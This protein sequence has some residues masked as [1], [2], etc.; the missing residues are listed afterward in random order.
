M[1]G[2]VQQVK[3]NTLVYKA[4]GRSLYGD[5]VPALYGEVVGGGGSLVDIPG[6]FAH[7]RNVEH[8]LGDRCLAGIDVGED[9]DVPNREQGLWMWGVLRIHRSISILRTSQIKKATFVGSL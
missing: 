9:A 2:G 3:L 8:T 4:Y 1:A 7:A 5:A 6:L